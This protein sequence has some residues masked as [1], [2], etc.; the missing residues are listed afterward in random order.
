MTVLAERP[1]VDSL[2]FELPAILEATEPPEVRGRGR[3]DVRLLVARRRDLHLAHG[4]F[5]QL[6][7]FLA[8]GKFE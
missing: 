4:R 1:T 7:E 8:S 2:D 6:P 3:D 5:W